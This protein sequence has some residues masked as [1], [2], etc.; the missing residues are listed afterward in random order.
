[1]DKIHIKGLEIFAHHGVYDEEK[2]KG[3]RFIINA[4]ISVNTA[5]AGES[6][7]IDDTLDYGKACE[8]IKD[9][10][11]KNQVN[12]LETLTNELARKLLLQYKQAEAVRIEICKPEAPIPMKFDS[13]SI[14]VERSR[15]TAYISIGSNMGD[16]EEYLQNAIDNLAGDECIK[17]KDVSNFSETKPYGGIEQEDFLNGMIKIETLYSPEELL[18]RLHTE[19]KLANRERKVHW[20]PRTLDLD[21]I[22]Y[23]NLVMSTDDLVIPHPDMANRLFVLEPLCEIAPN[24][25]HPRFMLTSN[26]LLLKLKT[27]IG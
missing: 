17:V 27:R 2:E 26:E 5:Y 11:V 1:M 14:E 23:D 3:Q 22:Y 16:R 24:M 15:H 12:L 18:E 25:I 19:E 20:G 9:F 4:D 6:D 8:F 13:V 10:M 21:I 7:D